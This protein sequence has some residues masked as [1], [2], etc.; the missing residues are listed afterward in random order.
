MT[1]T[2]FVRTDDAHFD[3]LS[4]WNH[5]PQ[6]PQMDQDSRL[7]HRQSQA[8]PNRPKQNRGTSLQSTN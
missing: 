3:A 6:A 5:D 7:D 2:D 8:S 1:V 4:D